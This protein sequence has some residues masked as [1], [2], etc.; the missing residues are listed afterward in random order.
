MN[1]EIEQ[2]ARQWWHRSQYEP[3]LD[4]TERVMLE[5]ALFDLEAVLRSDDVARA[6]RLARY[7]A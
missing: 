3:V 2:V 5:R 4:P 1:N 6:E 7:T